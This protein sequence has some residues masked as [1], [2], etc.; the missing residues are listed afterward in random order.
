MVSR[1]KFCRKAT[2]V[3]GSLASVS[4]VAAS[5]DASIVHVDGPISVAPGST[6]NL[7]WDIDGVGGLDIRFNTYAGFARDLNFIAGG[8]TG[9]L[10]AT[11]GLRIQNLAL[12]FEVGLTL[13]PGL[14]FA[15]EIWSIIKAT[16]PLARFNG[17]T[18]DEPGFVGFRFNDGTNDLFG[19][20]K[21][22]VTGPGTLAGITIFEWAY[23]DS[24]AP[25]QVGDTGAIPEPS[26]LAMWALGVAGL[27]AWRRRRRSKPDGV[28]QPA[29]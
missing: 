12:G 11:N 28:T 24:G 18:V 17:F 29:A 4:L 25:I 22:A 2:A 15:N 19:W 23:E 21:F 6:A 9:A 20:A 1:R 10:V 13:E 26:S 16:S 5:A 3:A 8:G 7:D 14:A 27:A